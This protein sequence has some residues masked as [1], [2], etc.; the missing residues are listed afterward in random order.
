MMS[1]IVV[2]HD[3]NQDMNVVKAMLSAYS[4]L[5][6][7]SII[8]KES[9]WL[10]SCLSGGETEDST[11]LEEGCGIIR[12][13]IYDSDI[14]S[15][16]AM[17]MDQ[18]RLFVSVLSARIGK[19]DER[20]ISK[21][22][23][24]VSEH[25]ESL[26]ASNINKS[27]QAALSKVDFIPA[28][29]P[30]D[31]FMDEEVRMTLGRLTYNN[32][33]SP[34][35]ALITHGIRTYADWAEPAK[36]TLQEANISSAIFRYDWV[37]LLKFSYGIK[38]RDGYAIKFLAR[39][40][41]QSME[42]PKKKFSI[43]VHS[44]G[45]IV[46]TKALEIAESINIRINIDTVILNGS[47]LKKDYD[48]QRFIQE[49]K[50]YGVSIGRVVNICGDEDILPVIAKYTIYGA[51]NSGTFYF[52]DHNSDNLFNIRLKGAGHSN[53]L[54][55]KNVRELWSKILLGNVPKVELVPP[56]KLATWSDVF[57][58]WGLYGSA[59]FLLYR[60]HESA[61]EFLGYVYTYF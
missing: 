22:I 14:G 53:I 33:P 52:A 17:L 8:K 23:Y 55:N 41:Q 25:F 11:E 34:V 37:D 50:S 40:H 29:Y 49:G 18:K 1:N 32:S 54:D 48:W 31:I 26:N 56:S 15:S 19:Y 20:S 13:F 44:F 2:Y 59:G 4:G 9:S 24:F 39:I 36:D 21:L 6:F 45:S 61:L 30:S 38:S 10:H 60:Y 5:D 28:N 27:V 46:L 47:I 58:R 12:L 16:E 42:N 51:G 35:H 7:I 43:I 3:I 57:I